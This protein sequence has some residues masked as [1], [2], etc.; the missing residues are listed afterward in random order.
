MEVD[1]IQRETAPALEDL[2]SHAADFVLGIEYDP[3]PV[4]RHRAVH[5]QDLMRE[6]MLLALPRDHPAASQPGP[7]RLAALEEATWAT[8]RPG[9]G[10]EAFLRNVCNRIAGYEPNIGHRS[11]DAI[12]LSALVEAG[13]A[14]A[15]LPSMFNPQPPAS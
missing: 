4:A 11:D 12:V 7:V 13:R 2:R 15:L 14:V 9:T 1:V 8:G 3:L 5:R 10:L 6:D